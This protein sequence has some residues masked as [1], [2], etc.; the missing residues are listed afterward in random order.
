MPDRLAGK[1][2]VVTGGGSGNGRGIALRFAREG[3]DLVVL[4]VDGPGAERTAAELRTLGRRALALQADVSRRDQVEAAVDQA[5]REL[6][7]LHVLVNNAG[8]ERRAPFLDLQEEDWGRVMAVNVTGPFLCSQT[9]ARLMVADQIAGSIV[10]IT[11]INAHVA[12]PGAAHYIASK[13]ALRMLSAAMARDLA[14][15]GIRVNAVAPGVIDTPMSAASLSDP[16]RRAW[17]L[18]HIPLGRAGTPADV[19]ESVLFLAADESAY[20]TGSTIVVDGGWLVG[21]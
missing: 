16:E 10:N 19:A 3:A 1:T 13:G 18:N 7:P 20:I 4:D 17:M 8:I 11:S 6:G 12:F 5:H 14:E 2:A 21:G 15:H 9:L